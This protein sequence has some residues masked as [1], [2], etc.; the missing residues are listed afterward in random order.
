M[1]CSNSDWRTGV[2]TL[3]VGRLGE[4]EMQLVD[5]ELEEL[6]LEGL[7]LEELDLELDEAEFLERSEGGGG[8]KKGKEG[9]RKEEVE[10][11]L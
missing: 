10:A 9:G 8:R 4:P 7:E 6:E 11:L 1:L 5:L 2:G 3:V